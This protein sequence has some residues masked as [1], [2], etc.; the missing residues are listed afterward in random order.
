MLEL[1][2]MLVLTPKRATERLYQ[3]HPEAVALVILYRA[4]ADA[5]AVNFLTMERIVEFIEEMKPQSVRIESHINEDC[6]PYIAAL[7]D[8]APHTKH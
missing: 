6:T 3:I 2:D 7:S 4:G 8:Y 1:E 5:L